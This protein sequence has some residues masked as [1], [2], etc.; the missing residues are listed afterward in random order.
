MPKSND[1][2]R[3]LERLER[4]EMALLY[5]RRLGLSQEDFAQ[6]YHV[7]LRAVIAWERNNRIDCPDFSAMLRP[8]SVGEVCFLYR[9]RSGMKVKDVARELGLTPYWVSQIE[10]GRATADTLIGYWEC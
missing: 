1:D 6:L 2:L 7:G 8:L 5:R 3:E 4:G 10:R 9:R